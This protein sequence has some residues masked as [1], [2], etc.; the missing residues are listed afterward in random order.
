MVGL[1]EAFI[2]DPT[3][4]PSARFSPED[5]EP[6]ESPLLAKSQR[7]DL[8]RRSE[9]FYD[10]ANGGWGEFNKFIDTRVWTCSSPQR[11]VTPRLRRGR[12]RP[13]TPRSI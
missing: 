5:V 10:P 12:S 6:A 11:R 7:T 4:G 13:S 3:P 9:E 8:L 1:L 2:A